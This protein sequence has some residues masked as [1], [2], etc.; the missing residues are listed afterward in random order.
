MNIY[1]EA[2][3]RYDGGVFKFP[4]CPECGA[5][6]TEVSHVGNDYVCDVCDHRWL[7]RTHR[8]MAQALWAELQRVTKVVDVE[9]KTYCGEH[10]WANDDCPFCKADRGEI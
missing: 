4:D 6:F 7:K 10:C 2:A 9:G 3:R 5:K 1:K 8:Q